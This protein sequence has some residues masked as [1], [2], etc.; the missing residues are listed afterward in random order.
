MRLS[1]IGVNLIHEFEALRL[2]A[3]LDGGG[4]WTIGWGHT[5]VDVYDSLTC[6]KE[7]AD[8]W[9][10]EDVAEAEKSVQ[11]CISYPLTQNQYDALV[12]FEYNTGGLRSST[13]RKKINEGDLVGAAKEFPRW[14]KD[15]GKE[16]RGLTRRRLRE[17]ALFMTW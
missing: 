17:Q 1:P 13:L 8:A 9:F 6:T 14:N 2:K 16:V 10:T 11:D 7:Q 15:N 3:Y 4:V 5:G 12:S